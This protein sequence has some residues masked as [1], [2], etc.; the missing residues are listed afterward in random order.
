MTPRA[1]PRPSRTP[2]L[3]ATAAAMLALT[4]VAAPAAATNL[5]AVLQLA[6][7]GDPTFASARETHRAVY[8]RLDQ[9]RALMRP[10]IGINA[11][12]RQVNEN[13][14]LVGPDRYTYSTS[15][16]NL[17]AT[18]PLIRIPNQ[19]AAAQAEVQARAADEQL[20]Q[21]ELDLTLRTAK[22][23][24]DVLQAQDAL[25]A[26][27]AQKAAFTQQLA[28][29]KRALELGTAPITDVNEAQSRLDLTLAQE[30]AALNDLDVK[31]QALRRI[32]GT[33]LAAGSLARLRDDAKV[34][35][36]DAAALNALADRAAVE[37][38][39][40]VVARLNREVA[41]HEVQRQRAGHLPTVDLVAS[42]VDNRNAGAP[43]AAVRSD[44][45]Q[46][47]VGVEL[48]VPIYQGGAIS[49]REREAAANLSRAESDLE[50]AS[51]Q[52]TFDARQAMLGALSGSALVGALEQAFTSGRTQLQS[53][54]RGFEVGVR[55]RVD[56]LNAQ[57]QITTTWR[58]LS[59]ARYQ[60]LLAGLQLKAAANQLTQ[61]DLVALDGLLQ[62]PQDAA[63]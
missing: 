39:P 6:R 24:F 42:L 33:S 35:L 14:T 43:G 56:V 59:A 11:S 45:R 57:Q 50:A 25:G 53:T 52:A 54:Q 41:Q 51:R 18:Q 40:V 4:A 2:R 3:A 21:A 48:A 10:T 32:V 9:A 7:A 5:G 28:Q 46:R 58:D 12:A 36:P 1:F 38:L 31:Q 63:K 16:A 34:P 30:I 60:T 15:V 37:G 26:V 19:I 55:A 17:Q 8:A 22:A 29:A 62:E 44:S 20:R 61:E 27:R 49:A 13:S 23:Y 47:I